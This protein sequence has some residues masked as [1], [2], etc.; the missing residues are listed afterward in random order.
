MSP[1]PKS[2][3]KTYILDTNI[4]IHDPDAITGFGDNH[5]RVPVEVIQELDR[6]KTE[7]S[8]RGYGARNA[9]KNLLSS[10]GIRDSSNAPVWL[11]G[12]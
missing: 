11:P 3:Q 8:D 10:L 2:G 4:L 7:Q 1:Q 6:I 12:G 5:V 9:V